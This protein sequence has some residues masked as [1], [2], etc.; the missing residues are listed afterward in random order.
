MKDEH[1][2]AMECPKCGIVAD[3]WGVNDR[4]G[5]RMNVLRMRPGQDEKCVLDEDGVC[6]KGGEALRQVKDASHGA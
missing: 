2:C 1:V 5:H 6:S 3:V 4:P